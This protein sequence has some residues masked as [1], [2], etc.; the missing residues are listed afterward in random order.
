MLLLI[1][2]Q[3]NVSMWLEEDFSVLLNRMEKSAAFAVVPFIPIWTLYNFKYDSRD[4][5]V[6]FCH[7]EMSERFH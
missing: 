6:I 3:Q 1:L 7:K 5:S 4:W 2:L